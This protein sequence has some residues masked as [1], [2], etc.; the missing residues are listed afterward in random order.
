VRSHTVMGPSFW[1]T[2][3]IEDAPAL[4]AATLAAITGPI[5]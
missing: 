2:T 4:V 3:E 5:P 1:Q